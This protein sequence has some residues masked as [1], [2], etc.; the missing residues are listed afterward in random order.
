MLMMINFDVMNIICY[1]T[2]ILH[3]RRHKP[4]KPINASFDTVGSITDT[5]GTQMILFFV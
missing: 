1:V 2:Y 5:A 3:D 4:A